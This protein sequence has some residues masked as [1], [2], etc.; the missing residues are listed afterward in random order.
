[1]PC[2]QRKI[3]LEH[4]KRQNFKKNFKYLRN[5]TKQNYVGL[6]KWP[7]FLKG[8]SKTYST[9]HKKKKIKFRTAPNKK[10]TLY[11]RKYCCG[12]DKLIQSLQDMY[13]SQYRLQCRTLCNQYI[14]GENDVCRTFALLTSD[15]V[16]LYRNRNPIIISQVD[17]DI[18]RY[19]PIFISLL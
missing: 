10:N 4:C 8:D 14:N 3:F 11:N 2:Q 19:Q 18:Y 13:Y 7:S 17:I 15:Y 5:D 9:F 1:M 16:L 6:L 12:L